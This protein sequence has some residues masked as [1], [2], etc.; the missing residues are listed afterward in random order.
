MCIRDSPG[1]EVSIKRVKDFYD[2]EQDDVD[3]DK[4]LQNKEGNVIDIE[5]VTFAYENGK[6]VLDLSLIHI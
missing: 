3:I 5:N 6:N 1:Y 4:A 2:N